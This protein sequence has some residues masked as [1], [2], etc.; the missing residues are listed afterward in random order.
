MLTSVCGGRLG[1]GLIWC[2]SVYG[3][4]HSF[5]CLVSHNFPGCTNGVHENLEQCKYCQHPWVIGGGHACV[6]VAGLVHVVVAMTTEKACV[7]DN[8]R[9]G[10]DFDLE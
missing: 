1:G 4:S 7:S 3:R 9:P 6:T 2:F 10:C 5:D 8:E